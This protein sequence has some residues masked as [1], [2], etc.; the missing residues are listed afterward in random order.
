MYVLDQH[1]AKKIVSRTMKI[2]GHNI[3]VMN[4]QGVILGSGDPKRIGATHEGALLAIAQNRNVELSEEVASGLHGV[5]PGINLPL[6]YQGQIIGVIG[7]TGDPAE[8]TH[9]G[10][11]LKMTAEMI[12]EQANQQDKLQWE[13]R[14][15]EEFILQLI[16]AQTDDDEQLHRWAKQ[17]D[18]DITLPRV[19]AIIEVSEK[20]P[21]AIHKMISQVNTST[22]NELSGSDERNPRVSETLKQVLH[23]LQNPD[24]G[25]LI[26]MTSMSQLVILKPA[27]LDGKQWDPELENQRI[28]KLL[29]RLPAQMDL[30]FKI[31]LG[32]FFPVKGGIARSYQTAQETLSLGKQLNPEGTKYLFE[33]YSLQ[34]LLSGLKHDWRGQALASPYQQLTQADKNG[35]LRKTLAAYITHFGDAQQCANALFIHRNTL[36]Y[37]LDK[38]QQLTKTDI[39]SLHGLLSLYLGQLLD[40]SANP[41]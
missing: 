8:L 17:L 34:V 18:I 7:I 23:L 9:Y 35:Q 33:D 32:H 37:R 20:Q 39:Q 6:H 28:D 29:Q 19:A 24:R 1:I 25:N 22:N 38:I 11:L 12:V 13:N 31:A 15:R 16:K 3:N 4:G 27:F 40:T 5:K 26:A 14:Q 30:N 21:S 2:I 36:R 41:K 10:E